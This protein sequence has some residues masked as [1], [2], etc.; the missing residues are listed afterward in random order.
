LT[1]STLT[2]LTSSDEGLATLRLDEEVLGQSTNFVRS[3]QARGRGGGVER[4]MS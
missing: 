4:T 2:P 1:L 3:P